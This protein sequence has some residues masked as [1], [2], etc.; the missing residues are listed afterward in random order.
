MNHKVKIRKYVRLPMDFQSTLL[1]ILFSMIMGQAG[2]ASFDCK[3][4]KYPI[5]IMLCEDNMLSALDDEMATRYF[6][7]VDSLQGANKKEFVGVQRRF[8]LD[9]LTKCD[10]P[11]KAPMG[12]GQVLR[13]RECLISEYKKRIDSLDATTVFSQLDSSSDGCPSLYGMDLLKI[14]SGEFIMGGANGYSDEFPPHLI[15]VEEFCLMKNIFTQHDID[16]LA[17]LFPDET[18]MVMPDLYDAQKKLKEF[19]IDVEADGLDGP[20][21]KRAI[22]QFQS[23]RGIQ[24]TGHLT[25]ETLELLSINKSFDEVFFSNLKWRTAQQLA[26]FLTE[27]TGHHVRLP[28]EAEWEYAA[29]G[30]LEQKDYPWG[31]EEESSITLRNLTMLRKSC[32]PRFITSE[33]NSLTNDESTEGGGEVSV[34]A[35]GLQ[36]IIGNWQ[37]TSS[38]Y[39]PYPYNPDDGRED[40]TDYSKVRILRGGEGGW[41]FC[42]LRVSLRAYGSDYSKY[43]FRFVIE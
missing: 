13:A 4:A 1:L 30:G 18:F 39:K 8:L 2:A 10:I 29:R 9:R 31:N 14:P 25:E 43:S 19:G 21:T 27:K 5:E 24:E 17:A 16:R 32:H 7:F 3:L 20:K 35:Y 37:W 28:T 22:K 42:D 36:S 38:Q 33:K 6:E 12:I 11:R 23:E 26:L 15:H 34:N 40:I 41:E